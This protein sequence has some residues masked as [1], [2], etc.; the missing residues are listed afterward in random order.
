MFVHARGLTAAQPYPVKTVRIIVTFPPGGPTDIVGR[1]LAQKFTETFKQQFVVDN[2]AGAGGVI[3]TDVAAKSAP[4]GHTLLLG[5]SSGLSLNPALN[6]KLPYNAFNDFAPISLVVI[7]PQILVLH[8]SLPANSVK[9]LIRLAKARPGQI[10]YASVGQGSPNHLGIEMLKAMAGIDMVHIPYKGTAPALTDLLAGQVSLM[11]N[12]MPSVLPQV[13]S[14][15][16]KGIAVGSA[17]RS[18]AAPEIPTVSE[19]GVPGF[20]YVTWYGLFA[21]AATPR[22]IVARLNTEVV[23]ILADPELAQRFSSQGAE[24]S[25]TTPEQLAKFQRDEHERWKRVIQSAGIKLE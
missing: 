4:D 3:G 22:D 13:K 12:S 14:G 16:L 19:A 18:P 1:S 15:K 17:K 5:T 11:F 20:E 25:S 24:P 8:P 6:P 21:P 2:R 9:D 7:N 23:R 10:N